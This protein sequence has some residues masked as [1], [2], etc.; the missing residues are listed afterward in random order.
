[1]ETQDKVWGFQEP[2][3]HEFG[4]ASVIQKTSVCD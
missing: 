3:L 2:W 1:M 4:S